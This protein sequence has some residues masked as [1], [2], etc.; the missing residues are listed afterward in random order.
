[1]A[2]LTPRQLVLLHW[3]SRGSTLD[4]IAVQMHITPLTVRTL[5]SEI[6]HLLSTPA[7]SEAVAL[8]M[9]RLK[10][11]LMALPLGADRNQFGRGGPLTPGALRVL[12]LRQQCAT[13]KQIVEETGLSVHT[14]HGYQCEI[15]R[16][17]GVQTLRDAVRRATELKLLT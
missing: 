15:Y 14:I 6:R 3:Y 4:E 9:P 5:V 16:Q 12:R 13:T 17:L 10:A 7:L 8:A 2:R 1:V 11:E